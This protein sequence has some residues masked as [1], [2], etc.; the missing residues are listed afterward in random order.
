MRRDERW[1]T[2]DQSRSFVDHVDDAARSNDMM[3]RMDA[4]LLTVVR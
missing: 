1:L 3:V 4:A 2:S